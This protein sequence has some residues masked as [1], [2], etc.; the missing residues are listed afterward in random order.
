MA[1]FQFAKSLAEVA[2]FFLKTV[3]ASLEALQMLKEDQVAHIDFPSEEVSINQDI[4][5][6]FGGFHDSGNPGV[7][8]EV[9]SAPLL[10]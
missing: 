4:L 8:F 7:R 6:G 3:Q 1:M 5:G 2:D 9:M 10:A